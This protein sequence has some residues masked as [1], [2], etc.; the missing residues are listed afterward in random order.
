MVSGISGVRSYSELGGSYL[1]YMGTFIWSSYG[2]T[3]KTGSSLWSYK[4]AE[5]SA[6]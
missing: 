3:V 6:V 1:N 5:H 4:T 2:V